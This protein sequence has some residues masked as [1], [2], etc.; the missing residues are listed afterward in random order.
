MIV[1]RRIGSSL[2]AERGSFVC[3]VTFD[4][5]SEGMSA[6]RWRDGRSTNVLCCLSEEKC[7]GLDDASVAVATRWERAYRIKL[8]AS[9]I[10]RDRW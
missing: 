10:F 5:V 7:V 1:L 4:L 9:D 3:L 2:P 6:D 8:Q